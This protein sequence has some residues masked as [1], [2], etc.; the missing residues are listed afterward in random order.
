VIQE[1]LHDLVVAVPRCNVDEPGTFKG[2]EAHPLEEELE[3]LQ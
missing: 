1:S 3:D 2:S